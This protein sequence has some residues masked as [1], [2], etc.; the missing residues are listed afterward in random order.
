MGRRPLSARDEATVD[1]F[2]EVFY[3]RLADGGRSTLDLIWLGYRVVKCPFDLW[4]YQEILV[5]TRPT[6]IVEC[7]T[8]FGGTSLFLA[9]MFD[10][11]GGPGRVLTIDIEELPKRPI[12]PR[13]E[14]VLGSTLDADVIARVHA[15]AVGQ[16][17][18]LILDSDHS[19]HH[20]RAEL[21][22]YHDIVTPGCYLIVEDTNV[23][24]HPVLPDFGPGPME[25]VDGFLAATSGFTIDRDRERFLVSL[26][27]RGYLHRDA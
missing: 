12:H 14:Y 15:A 20:V 17:T 25:A 26:N 6:L 16:R 2:H 7:G 22:A 4:T 10:L 1:A 18:M 24:G 27:P 3:E 5:E 8:K 23:N 13:I 9:S 11:I 21:D 19:E